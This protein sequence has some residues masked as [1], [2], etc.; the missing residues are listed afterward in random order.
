VPAT[1]LRAGP[2]QR[3]FRFS[4]KH[5]EIL[6]QSVDLDANAETLLK[7]LPTEQKRRYIEIVLQGSMKSLGP[8]GILRYQPVIDA[9]SPDD[10]QRQQLV[11]TLWEDTRRYL[12]IPLKELPALDK[13]T[14][15]AVDS[16]LTSEQ[17]ATL[18][19]FLGESVE[20]LD[21]SLAEAALPAESRGS[22]PSRAATTDPSSLFPPPDS[23]ESRGPDTARG[24]TPRRLVYPV[25]NGSAGEFAAVLRQR[26]RTGVDVLDVGA[27]VNNALRIAVAP[28]LCNELLAALPELD[29]PR[30]RLIVDI[31]IAEMPSPR[32]VDAVA[33][34][35][36]E[37]ADDREFSGPVEQVQARLEALSRQKRLAALRQ[38]RLAVLEDLEDVGDFGE[39]V[40]FVSA[41]YTP[42]Q[43]AFAFST[44]RIGFAGVHVNVMS[45]VIDDKAA[46]L[47]LVARGHR[48]QIPAQGAELGLGADGPLAVEE[49]IAELV[50]AEVRVPLGQAVLAP[51][52]KAAGSAGP[53]RLRVV[54]AV[55][56]AE[57]TPP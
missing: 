8:A 23:A 10:K 11:E 47:R 36:Q 34:G 25:R 38:I 28:D 5:I 31:M 44:F 39:N 4:D 14:S 40:N 21:F 16:I 43:M 22:N 3:A 57:S 18:E 52:P 50:S 20:K 26:F 7:S 2:V 46:I 29:R 19:K 51:A 55:R 17:R 12:A 35:D 1:Y 6:Y 37:A 33:S 48:I 30:Q 32:D 45:R 24:A 15:E 56:L 27:P 42:P 13:Q 54:V 9:L 53:A 41:V 49:E